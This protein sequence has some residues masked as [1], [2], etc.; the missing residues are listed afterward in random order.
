ML[1][2]MAFVDHMNFDI[3]VKDLYIKKGLE[4]PKLDYNT[5]FKDVVTQKADYIKTFLFVAKPDEFLMQDTKLASYY[6]WTTG[7]SNTKYMEVI[8]GRY[9]ARPTTDSK[10][11]DIGDRSSYYKVEKGTDINLGINIISKAH[12]N[13]FDVAFVF[14]ADT[15]YINVYRLLRQMG[16]IV[17][18]VVVDGQRIESLKPEVDD[19]IILKKEFFLSHERKKPDVQKDEPQKTALKR[20]AEKHS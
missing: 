12:N 4:A 2:G 10:P 20:Y 18:L 14:S 3:A 9:V 16:K 6:K 7:L 8:F 13:A 15:D 5:V 19:F 17:V 11:M 1:R